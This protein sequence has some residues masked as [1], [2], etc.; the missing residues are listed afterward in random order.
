MLIVLA[1][2]VLRRRFP[3][4]GDAIETLLAILEIFD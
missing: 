4:I 1:V 3:D 2:A